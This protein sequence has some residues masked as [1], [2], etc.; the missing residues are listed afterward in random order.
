MGDAEYLA[1][2]DAIIM[3]VARAFDPELVIVS[4]GFDAAKGDLV[5]GMA[6]TPLGFAAM[7]S[8]LRQLAGG[9]ILMVLEGGYKPVVASKGVQAC[10]RV[11]LDDPSIG[12]LPPCATPFSFSRQLLSVPCAHPAHIAESVPWTFVTQESAGFHE[13]EPGTRRFEGVV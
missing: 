13:L 6:I 1:A 9:R 2:F 7:T 12:S 4:A 5:G 11:L 3:P 8:R 10:L